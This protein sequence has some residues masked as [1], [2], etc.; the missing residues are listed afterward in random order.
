MLVIVHL[1]LIFYSFD[2]FFCSRFLQCRGPFVQRRHP[3]VDASVITGIR[4]CLEEG[5]EFQGDLL[6]FRKDGSPYMARLQI[7]PIYGDDEIITH[8][9]GIQFFNDSNVDLGSSP[10]SVAKELARSTWIAPDNT[11]SPTSVAKRN[12]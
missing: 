12:L 8:Y 9:M 10:G 2:V 5:T 1:C 7:T 11:G 3:L 6:N 4:R